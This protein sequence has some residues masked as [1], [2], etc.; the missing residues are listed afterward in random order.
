ML[1]KQKQGG[2]FKSYGNSNKELNTLIEKKFQKF[3]E[4]KK[5]KKIEKELQHFQ[6]IQLS[7]VE[8][9]ISVSTMAFSAENRE[10]L[11]TIRLR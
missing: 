9:I 4:N 11:S 3:V 1:N 7:D 2:K 5:K 8:N 10:I 6:K